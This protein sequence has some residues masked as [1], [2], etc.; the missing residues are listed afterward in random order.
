MLLSVIIPIGNLGRD[1]R[2]L[3]KIIKSTPKEDVELLFVLDTDEKTAFFE[4][5]ELCQNE[6]LGHYKILFCTERNPGS[7]RNIGSKAAEGKWI[8]FC[9]SDDT[10]VFSNLLTTIYKADTD[11]NIVIGS[12][13]TE[14]SFGIQAL[15]GLIENNPTFNWLSVTLNPGLWRWLIRKKLV[16]NISFP[17]LSIG[18]DQFFLIRLLAS[19][20]Q[21]QFS[22]QIFYVY[23]IDIKGSL[24]SDKAKISDLSRNIES[25]IAYIV[26]IKNR[27]TVIINMIFRQ[28]VTLFKYGNFRLKLLALLFSIKLM[29]LLS[30]NAILSVIKFATRMIKSHN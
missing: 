5:S 18:E 12:F 29:L 28:I 22:S 7:S 2:N 4:L 17:E 19:T 30:P 1:Y 11:S 25:E 3:N 15:A 21:I 23:R 26:S 16:E 24:T 8:I 10:P 13:V 9:D 6:N 27:N 20:S 14:N